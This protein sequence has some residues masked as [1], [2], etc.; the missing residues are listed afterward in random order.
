MASNAQTQWVRLAIDGFV[1]A[2]IKEAVISPGSRSTPFVLAALENKGLRCIRAIDERCASFYALGQARVTGIPSL[3]I[4]T[5]GSAAA[6]YLPAVVEAFESHVPVIVLSADRPPEL[7]NCGVNQTTEQA[8]FFGSH[9]LSFVDLGVAEPTEEAM[10]SVRRIAAE[11][12][13]RSTGNRPG[14]VHINA[15]ARKPLEKIV[16]V[17]DEEKA[18]ERLAD[19]LIEEKLERPQLEVNEPRRESIQRLAAEL[20]DSSRPLIVCGPAS[21]VP[22]GMRDAFASFCDTY[23]V[24]VFA[25]STSQFRH[26][27]GA[28]SRVVG[29]MQSIFSSKEF[30][31]SH[32]PDFVLQIGNAPVCKDWLDFAQ[33]DQARR[34]VFAANG[35]PDPTRN[36]VD[37]LHGDVEAMLGLIENALVSNTDVDFSNWRKWLMY[38]DEQVSGLATSI[39]SSVDLNE[40]NIPSL[41]VDALPDGSTLMVGNSLPIRQLDLY[42]APTDKDVRIVSQRGVSGIDGMVSGAAGVASQVE[43]PTLLLVGDVSFLHDVGGLALAAAAKNPLVVLVVNNAGGRIF[44][45]L[46]V[47][48][49]D[50][51]SVE[52]FTTPHQVDLASAVAAYGVDFMRTDKS[53][54][55]SDALSKALREPG[56]IVIEAV[57]PPHDAKRLN[58]LLQQKVAS[59]IAE[60]SR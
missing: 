56:C 2:G 51:T 31:E 41:V 37:V 57:V 5:S 17:T 14:P 59:V 27:A 1:R 20:S 15:P 30:I 4:C 60:S 50:V 25:E 12:V 13:W 52:F 10:R 24:P 55:L 28:A 43:G 58:N 35:N 19:A 42:S 3:L 53:A 54:E 29:S 21:A 23:P 38:L 34:F 22:G 33:K 6:H 48:D 45:Q 16:A 47:A 8:H 36:A 44:E 46:P 49:Q 32:A 40:A 11:A 18:L 26:T 39:G 9:V 7:K